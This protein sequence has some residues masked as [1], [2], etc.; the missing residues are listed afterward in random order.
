MAA[1]DRGRLD[2]AQQLVELRTDDLR[3][4][5]PFDLIATHTTFHH[6]RDVP[7]TL[8]RL[9]TLL[10]PGGRL[11]IVDNCSERPA[12][13]RWVYQVGAFVDGPNDWRRHGAAAAARL[14]RFRLSRAWLDHLASD[15]YLSEAGFHEAYGP[16]LPGADF[17][18]RFFMRI[19]WTAPAGATRG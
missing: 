14:F 9:K 18:R 2:L 5:G 13:P 7:A 11:L 3:V 6:L 4:E 8:R 16:E 10:R 1:L 19:A 15:R 17:S 12:V